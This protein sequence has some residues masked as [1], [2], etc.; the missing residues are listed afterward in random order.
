MTTI[1]H[2]LPLPLSDI[3][4][5]PLQAESCALVVVDI[6]RKL[7]PPIFNKEHLVRNA[8]LLIRLANI[9]KIPQGGW[10]PVALGL[11]VIGVV[12]LIPFINVIAVLA[13]LLFGFG[14]IIRYVKDRFSQA[15]PGAGT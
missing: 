15:A 5:M 4:R 1:G 8:S 13:V 10:F 9:L 7:L 3:A 2:V 6:Q 12:E 11:L 14:A